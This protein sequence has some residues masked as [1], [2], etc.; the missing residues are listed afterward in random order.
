[1]K[2]FLATTQ[3]RKPNGSHPRD[4]SELGT[5]VRAQGGKLPEKEDCTKIKNL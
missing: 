1:M 4:L 5:E 2:S 3:E